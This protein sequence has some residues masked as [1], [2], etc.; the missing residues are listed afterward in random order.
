VIVRVQLNL[1]REGIQNGRPAVVLIDLSRQCSYTTVDVHVQTSGV[2][3]VIWPVLGRISYELVYMTTAMTTKVN[4][5]FRA[6]HFADDNAV[7]WVGTT[8]RRGGEHATCSRRFQYTLC[9]AS[10]ELLRNRCGDGQTGERAMLLK[11]LGTNGTTDQDGFVDSPTLSHQRCID[12][13]R[14]FKV[15]ALRSVAAT[16]G[17]KIVRGIVATCP[18]GCKHQHPSTSLFILS[19]Y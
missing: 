2:D 17:S 10:T 5:G 19:L 12:R 14:K 11:M 1:E 16:S 18:V 7:N 8:K 15:T 9:A 4:D 6:V 3:Y 13:Y